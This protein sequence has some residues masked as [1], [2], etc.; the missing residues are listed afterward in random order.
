MLNNMEK[1]TLK[2]RIAGKVTK[3]SGTNTLKVEVETKYQHPKYG[4]I[5][6]THKSYLVHNNGELGDVVVGNLVTIEEVKPISKLK[7]WLLVEINK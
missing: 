3:L 2:R 7:R 4:K 5:I 6:K 1:K